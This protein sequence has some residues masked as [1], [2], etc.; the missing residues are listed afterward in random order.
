ML[1]LR[2]RSGYQRF[3]D[4]QIDVG[5]APDVDTYLPGLVLSQFGQQAVTT[6]EVRR[7]VHNQI[8]SPHGEP[9]ERGIAFVTTGVLVVIAPE[10]DDA[11]PPHSRF[12]LDNSSHESDQSPGIIPLLLV[13]DGRNV[14][15]DA[16]ICGF[17]LGYRHMRLQTASFGRRTGSESATSEEPTAMSE[18]AAPA[19]QAA[20]SR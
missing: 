18:S 5:Q 11:R 6:L 15:L 10:A 1:H 20:G 7:D 14:A 19:C 12:L 9:R 2:Y 3:Q 17:G 4:L 16:D 8:T 13:R